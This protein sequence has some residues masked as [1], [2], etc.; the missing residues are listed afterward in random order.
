MELRQYFKSVLR[1]WWLIVLST[2][3]AAG[4]SYYASSK[5]PRIYE[6]TTTLLVGQ[7]IQKDNPTGADFA[8]TEQLAE[9]YA[10]MV[11]R[12]PVLQATVDSLG[13][14]MN[15]QA[16]RGQ[17][18]AYSIPRTQLLAITVQDVS[19]ERAVAIADQVA[20]QLILQ[21]PSS[22]ENRQRQERSGFVRN[23][24]DELEKRIE[25]TQAR[26][27]ELQAELE[28]AFSA[29]QIQ[30]LQSEITSLET[31]I[32]GW[33]EDYL[34]LLEFVSGGN[35]PNYL[36]VIE[37]AQLPY[38][39]VSPNVKINVLLAAAVGFML[40]VS[41][42]LVLEY[43]DDTIRS[44]DE[45]SASL[46]VAVLG[47]VGR[48]KGEDYK[49]K[50]ITA[51]G[52]LSSISED[53][54]LVRTNVQYMAVD[55]PARS[56]VVTSPNP[57]E[58]KSLTAANLGVIMAQANLRTVIVDT[59]LRQPVMH[60]I[61]RVSNLEGVTD[62]LRSAKLDLNSQLKD[63]GIENL[64]VVTSGPLPPNSAEMLGSQRMAELVQRLKEMADVIIFDSSP[65]LA[66]TDAAVLSSRVDGVILVTQAKRTRRDAVKQAVKRLNQVGANILGSVLN[67]VPG[68]G[69]HY[70]ARS[71]YTRSEHGLARSSHSKSRRSWPR[72]PV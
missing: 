25:T 1:W 32:N 28:T 51:H 33:Q 16:L 5:Q 40:A 3:L 48:I 22:P 35:S 15:W 31:L 38:N 71:F 24:L 70:Y 17:V 36:S 61:F 23:Q 41:A 34:A 50:L 45:L 60:K 46:G 11:L 54:R 6:T 62:L 56:I 72:L 66:V 21:S 58:G 44:T 47:S 64:K 7:V 43:L 52:P 55:Q 67:R 4:A 27:K 59:D 68:R 18:F 9:S 26:V 8:T 30:D 10:Q 53:Y 49:D 29:R 20:Y 63:T 37:E 57:G 12:Q 42:A 14:N 39:P 19:P 13:L 2:G 65:V 69:D